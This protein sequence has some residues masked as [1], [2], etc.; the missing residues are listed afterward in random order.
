[1]KLET[2]DVNSYQL[3]LSSLCQQRILD[4][5][6]R[7]DMLVEFVDFRDLVDYAQ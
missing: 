4:I 3:V 2:G 7:L 6:G 5:G 1:M